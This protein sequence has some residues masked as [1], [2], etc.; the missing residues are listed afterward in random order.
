MGKKW[1]TTDNIHIGDIFKET[2]RDECGSSCALYQVVGKR[3]KTLVEQLRP[4]REEDFVDET[5]NFGLGQVWV[6]PLPGQFFEDAEIITVG[7]C[8]PSAIDGRNWLNG[9][10]EDSWRCFS[11][12]RDGEIA[13]LSGYDGFY[14]INKLKKE[15]KLPS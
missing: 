8:M 3:A 9:R 4:I 10:G 7:V 6:R 1:P 15:G 5:C 14:A 11:E 2:F 12:M 13:S